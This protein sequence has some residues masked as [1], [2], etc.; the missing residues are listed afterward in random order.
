MK[1][2][3]FRRG[4][5]WGYGLGLLG[6]LVVVGL[7]LY[8][9]GLLAES[10]VGG[11]AAGSRTPQQVLDYASR[12]TQAVADRNK[13]FEDPMNAAG[14]STAPATPDANGPGR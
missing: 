10:E 2:R 7:M 5:A 1:H 3:N 12:T 9:T 11:G 14:A 6:L 4:S 13:Q 8:M